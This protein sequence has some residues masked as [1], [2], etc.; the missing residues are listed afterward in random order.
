V[1][2]EPGV[3]EVHRSELAEGPEAEVEEVD[4]VDSQ[5]GDEVELKVGMYQLPKKSD[6]LTV[7]CF[8]NP[9]QSIKSSALN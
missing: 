8:N 4:D 2:L 7:P 5:H 3:Q 9:H 6:N 1:K